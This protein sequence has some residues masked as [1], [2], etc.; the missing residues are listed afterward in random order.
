MSNRSLPDDVSHLFGTF[1]KPSTL[2]YLEIVRNEEAQR[3][4][5]RWPMFRR[6]KQAG[7]LLGAGLASRGRQDDEA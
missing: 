6:L 3:A 1:R 5:E 4:I 7:L 2:N